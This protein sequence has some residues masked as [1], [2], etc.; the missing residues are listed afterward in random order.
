MTSF[1]EPP[2]FCGTHT[3]VVMLQG[4]LVTIGEVPLISQVRWTRVRDDIS[5]A[6]ID[7]PIAECCD[8]LNLI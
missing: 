8:L 3:A 7:I 4:G 5:T 6:Q 2:A 1:L